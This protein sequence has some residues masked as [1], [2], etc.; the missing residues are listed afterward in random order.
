MTL[1]LT[2]TEIDRE[3]RDGDIVRL[4][5]DDGLTYREI[6]EQVGLSISQ[7]QRIFEAARARRRGDYDLDKHH[8]DV[9][10]D[11]E[12]TLDILRP[13]IMGE[14]VPDDVFPPPTRDL[15]AQ[16][17]R[18]LKAK[19]EFLAL[20]APIRTEAVT[21]DVGGGHPSE[22][23]A[24]FLARLDIWMTKTHTRDENGWHTP[25]VLRPGMTE[26][27]NVNGHPRNVGHDSGRPQGKGMWSMALEN[28]SED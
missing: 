20:D 1:V 11:I 3:T 15:F 19:R 25:P 2:Q 14:A 22:D 16:W 27:V 8:R 21:P 24:L 7:C 6:A 17:W 18:A 5:V 4:R 10:N 13:W 26:R 23:V 28:P 12:D 9:L